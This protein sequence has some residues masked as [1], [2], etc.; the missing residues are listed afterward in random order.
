[1]SL[2]KARA[3][4]LMV[5]RQVAAD[6]AEARAL[7]MRGLVLITDAEG[8]ERK[9]GS[10]GERLA[11]E[12]SFRLKQTA[13]PYVSR[14]GLKL[15]HA[16]DAFGIEVRDR[17]AADIGLSTG[18]FTDCLLQRG[19]ARVHGVDVAYGTVAWKVRQDPRVVLHERTNARHITVDT[20]GEPVELMVV[21]LS[22]VSTA[23]LIPV[24]TTVLAS[25]AEMIILV[26]PQF[27]APKGSTDRGIVRD[28]EV[29]E[30]AVI[31]VIRAAGTAGLRLVG[32]TESPIAG[33]EGNIEWLLHFEKT[34]ALESTE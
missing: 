18:G 8:R 3:D 31:A 2:K 25:T 21:D 9:V 1:M 30:A 33:T 23:S 26:K 10:A 28:P 24:L 14:A 16:L 12:L 17:V 34:L 20:F 11:P 27:E 22:F 5:E 29:R 19:A 13:R 32:R 7:I 15:A 4:E 6:L